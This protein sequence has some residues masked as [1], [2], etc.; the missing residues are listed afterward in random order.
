MSS[1][2]DH[3]LPPPLSPLNVYPVTATP[4]P[5]QIQGDQE[6]LVFSDQVTGVF[7]PRCREETRFADLYGTKVVCCPSCKGFLT[8]GEEFRELVA[9]L[10]KQYRGPE[11]RPQPLNHCEMKISCQCPVCEGP[12]E[13]HPYAGPGAVVIDSCAACRVV[14]LD[15]GELLK[16]KRNPGRR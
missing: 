6:P 8:R 7:C 1:G 16:I 14:W 9:K 5:P 4:G 13:T 2:F 15:C 3:R 12:M 10:R 11:L